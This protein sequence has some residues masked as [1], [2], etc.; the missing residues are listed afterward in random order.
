[1]PVVVGIVFA[2]HD[3]VGVLTGRSGGILL[4]PDVAPLAIL[5]LGWLVVG[6]LVDGLS[7]AERLNRDLERRVQ[8]K[9]RELEANYQRLRSLE[10]EQA[11]LDERDRIMGDMHDGMGAHLVSALALVESGHSTPV[12]VAEALRSALDDLRLMI[13]SLEP[14]DEDLITALGAVRARLESRLERNGIRLEWQVVDL[15]AIPGFGPQRVL[16]LL[17]IVQEAITNVIKHARAGTVFVRTG[18][19]DGPDGAAGLFVEIC[20]DGDGIDVTRPQGN[21]L[22]NMARRAQ[23]LGG[24]LTL[25]AA[26]PGTAVRLWLPRAVAGDHSSS[27]TMPSCRA[28]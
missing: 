3:V 8:E 10:R 20:D 17:R 2:L 16:Q 18:T 23:A 22:A 6:R 19:E 25:A 1:V 21:G 14:V 26:R 5:A 7:D 27:L 12:R 4:S 11:V 15:P 28:S 9:H 24:R 13:A